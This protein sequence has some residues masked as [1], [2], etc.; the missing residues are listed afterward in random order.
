MEVAV[1][2]KAFQI[3]RDDDKTLIRLRI[4]IGG[5]PSLRLHRQTQTQGVQRFTQKEHR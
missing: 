4:Y 2:G 3:I 5:E 1:T